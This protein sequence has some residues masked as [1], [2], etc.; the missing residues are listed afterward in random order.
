MRLRNQ[1]DNTTRLLNLLLSQRRDP[2]GLDNHRDFRETDLAKHLAEAGRERVN[3]WDFRGRRRRVA[4]DLG[5]NQRPDLV[6]VDNWL[7]LRVAQEVEVTHT[8]LTEV[9]WVVLVEVGTVVV[10]TTGKTTTTW[11]LAVLANTTVTGRNVSTV[12]PGLVKTSRHLQCMLA[13]FT[14]IGDKKQCATIRCRT[15]ARTISR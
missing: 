10:E 6:Q 7:V 15:N 5:R 3:D 13:I 12:L 2:A 14:S 8:D 9:T 11:V 1:L 4:T